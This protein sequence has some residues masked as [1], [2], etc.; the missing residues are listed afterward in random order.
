MAEMVLG[1]CMTTFGE[2]VVYTPQGGV[3]IEISGIYDDLY[4]AV[5]PSTQAIVTS[6]QPILGIKN[7]TLPQVPR[8]GDT[9]TV[10]GQTYAVKEVQKDGQGGSRLFL[11]KA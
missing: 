5:D 6:E 7:N 11:H 9:L 1:A 4:E 3:P 10:R 8:Q 2:P